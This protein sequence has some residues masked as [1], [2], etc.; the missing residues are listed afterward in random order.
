MPPRFIAADRGQRRRPQPP[1]G[2]QPLRTGDGLDRAQR[3]AVL[4]TFFLSGVLSL[5]LEIVWFRMLV[6]YLR[7]TAYA[8]T[9]MLAVVLA[10][11]ALGQRAGGAA[12]A[13]APRL[14]A[15]PHGHPVLVGI[16]AVLSFNALA[17]SQSISRPC[18]A[19]SLLE[20]VG[21]DA[22]LA[23]IV[24]SSL[25]AMLP[26]TL[27]LGLAFPM[28]LSLWAG[29]AP[30]AETSR[31]VGVFYSL[32]VLG[33]IAGS[34][35]AGFVSLPA[36][37]SQGSLLA[38]SALAVVSSVVLAL[39][40]V[41]HPAE[42]RRLHGAGRPRRLRHGGAERRG[43]LRRGLR[44]LPPRRAAALAQGRRPDH[45]RDARTRA[46]TRADAVMYLDGMHQAND[47]RRPHSST[48]ASARCR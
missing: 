3:R 45:R 11:I 46:A 19:D 18:R 15:G 8:F 32:N 12:P 7:P 22:Y 39:D 26:A 5:A 44:A 23:P 17:R 35:L 33:A 24:V 25:A 14:A 28:G 43:S 47:C 10:G 38:A 36:L 6:V 31:R 4:W 21:L 48:S 16:A 2:R 41:A 40:A 20:A 29:D 27:L 30:S 13:A 9:I 34:V 42:L 1:A 37:G